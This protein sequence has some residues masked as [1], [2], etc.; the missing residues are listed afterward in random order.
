MAR[1]YHDQLVESAMSL[2]YDLALTNIVHLQT[3][4]L[5][6]FV[7]DETTGLLSLSLEEEDTDQIGE[8]VAEA[9][10]YLMDELFI[11]RQS[12]CP[13]VV[14]LDAQTASTKQIAFLRAQRQQVQGSLEWH[15]FREMHLTASNIWKCL[16]SAA[17]IASL[18]REKCEPTDPKR[19]MSVNLDTTLHWGHKYE[20][21]S[22][23]LY[24]HRYNT[25][26]GEFGCIQAPMREYLAASPD[27]INIDPTSDRF[28]RMVEVK[29]IVNRE[30]TGI[31]KQEYWVQMQIQM[32]VCELEYC[33]FVE[34]RFVEITFE[35]FREKG[36]CGEKQVG[37]MALF[38]TPAGAPVYE[39][40]EVSGG[41]EK[42]EAWNEIAMIRHADKQWLKN[43]FWELDEVSI[44]EVRF[45]KE[46]FASALPYFDRC[47]SRITT[48][49]ECGEHVYSSRKKRKT[50]H[51]SDTEMSELRCLIDVP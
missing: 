43:V 21:V 37:Y 35:Q 39:Y 18:V 48:E 34:T 11:P 47:W 2:M 32:A 26:V 49:R 28:G 4:S 36:L 30:I 25:S 7:E 31:P 6:G 42:Y 14:Q 46:W 10:V 24:E 9:S 3:G 1:P 33:D 13:P 45:N 17:N 8:A 16:G 12:A 50:N 40:G 15:A 23:S 51:N 19:Y 22:I 41:V 38:L 44:V 29:N 5:E 27:G 20:P